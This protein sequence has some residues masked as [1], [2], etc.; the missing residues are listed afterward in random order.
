MLPPN[1][2]FPLVRGRTGNQDKQLRGKAWNRRRAPVEKDFFRPVL[3][4]ESV[5][6]FVVLAL[7]NWLSFRGTMSGRS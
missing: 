3:L 2:A 4:G 6:P 5:A 7:R 1:P